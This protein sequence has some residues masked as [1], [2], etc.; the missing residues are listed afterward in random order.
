M[1]VEI[2]CVL[3]LLTASL[4]ISRTQVE[5]SRSAPDLDELLDLR[6]LDTNRLSEAVFEATNAQRRENGVPPL[7]YSERAER[8]AALQSELMRKRGALGHENPEAPN[9]RILEQR[10]EWAGLKYRFV[11]ENVATAF[12]RNYESGRPFY[13]RQVGGETV[14]SYEPRGE[15]IPHH[16]YATFADALV[17]SW[18]RSAGHRANILLR[19]AEFMGTSCL[20]GNGDS[21]MT[22]FYC[23]QVFFS[24]PRRSGAQ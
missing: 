20:P 10:A 22:T 13:L 16:T 4:P 3:F 19:Q 5:Q 2:V 23:T 24:P 15:P 21:E 11:A 14:V 6:S 12:G 8:A 1:R 17:K 7:R 9:W 18:M